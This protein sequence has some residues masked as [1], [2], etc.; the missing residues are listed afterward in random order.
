MGIDHS[1]E[2]VN[3]A[4]RLSWVRSIWDLAYRTSTL[5][6]CDSDSHRR[7]PLLGCRTVALCAT[8]PRI[9]RGYHRCPVG[10]LVFVTSICELLATPA[11][12]VRICGIGPSPRR[13]IWRIELPGLVN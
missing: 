9:P 3:K 4:R 2:L 8:L 11:F 1:A 7:D 12:G 5:S 6:H 13:S 10:L